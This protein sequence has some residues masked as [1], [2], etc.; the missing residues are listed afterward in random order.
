MS[1]ISRRLRANIIHVVLSSLVIVFPL[2]GQNRISGRVHSSG[3]QGLEGVSVQLM[4]CDT[5][6]LT[7]CST[8]S[9]GSFSLVT[10]KKEKLSLIFSFLGFHK[11]QV[12][13]Q[14]KISSD[15]D[16]GV[17]QMEPADI[18]LE[19]VTITASQ[20]V[21]KPD[22]VMIFPNREQI[23]YASTGYDLLHNLM[24]PGIDVDRM[25][26]KVINLKGEVDL[27]I[28]GKSASWQEIQAL[29]PKDIARVDYHENPQ[30][31]FAKS[32]TA[33][34]YI[35]K[36]HEYGGYVSVSGEQ[37]IGYLYGEYMAVAKYN[38]KRD[39]YTLIAGKGLER[40]STAG[41]T[42]ER[43]GF[44]NGL[45]ERKGVEN[46]KIHQSSQ[47]VMLGVDMWKNDDN[48]QIQA[49]YTNAL[50]PYSYVNRSLSHTGLQKD[51][52]TCNRTEQNSH[53]PYVQGFY[54]HPIS[55]KKWFMAQGAVAYT[56]S[57]YQRDYREEY[58]LPSEEP[59]SYHVETNEDYYRL[60]GG[61]IYY[62]GFL[63]NNYL[64][65]DITHYQNITSDRY[66]G[67]VQSKNVL[68]SG[69]T[70][71]RLIYGQTIQE[72]L[73]VLF[74]VGGSLNVYHIRHGKRQTT[75]SPRPGVQL[76]Y[77]S[78]KR[79]NWTFVGFMGNS[80]PDLSLLNNIEQQEDVLL[81]KRGNPELKIT[82]LLTSNLQYF[83]SGEKTSVSVG[84]DYRGNFNPVKHEFY[85]GDNFLIRTYLSDGS[86]HRIEPRISSSWKLFG[87]S[88]RLKV[89]VGL[90]RSVVTGKYAA[91]ETAWTGRCNIDYSLK[92]FSFRT[93]FISRQ[94]YITSIPYRYE[95]P[96][97]YGFSLGYFYKGF[98]AE[99]GTSNPFAHSSSNGM[100]Q[101]ADVYEYN[102]LYI[103]DHIRPMA[104]FRL[105]YNF[106]F[107]RKIKKSQASV[108]KSIESAIFK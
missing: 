50:T 77:Q 43:M 53:K 91:S 37:R 73:S 103:D 52:K 79:H 38:K 36:K 32:S 14:G 46:S 25:D 9:V 99:L 7:G 69:E 64:M 51:Y 5:I 92:A 28:D 22:R 55:S 90:I 104:Y 16:M 27:Y 17:V 23:R 48:W 60:V 72:K 71:L 93:Y 12:Q 44:S 1:K 81:V 107:G 18:L 101:I 85:E 74:S 89:D 19:S 84:V 95:V 29:R 59:Y 100:R 75:F 33:I 94:R 97:N 106:D 49:G 8:D 24:V 41:L 83:F 58:L 82:K 45:L 87:N 54:Y 102:N 96:E 98:S 61:F 39:T 105:S 2:S 67:D 42:E 21:R 70:Q 15:I 34:D 76:Q 31:R 80:T 62:C 26:K 10:D 47:Y 11:Q 40:T 56:R 66:V 86:Y 4:L 108:D 68:F 6:M 88:L 13:L 3:E 30:G 57:S 35:T 63:K 20:Y 78:G 65:T